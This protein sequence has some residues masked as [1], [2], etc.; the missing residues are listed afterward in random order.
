[1]SLRVGDDAPLILDLG[2]GVRYLGHQLR[3]EGRPFVGTALLT[4]LHW[5]HVQGLPFFPPVLDPDTR[6]DIYAPTQ[7][8]GRTAGTALFEM[9]KPP[10]F[11]VDISGLP[12]S[13]TV[14]TVGDEEFTVGRFAVTARFIPHIGPTLGYR[15]EYAGHSVAYLPDHQQPVDGGFDIADAVAELVD[16]ADVLIHDSQY[17]T[18]EFRHRATWGHCTGEYALHIARTCDVG[19]LVMF[20]HD[21]SR[22]DDD[23]ESNLTCWNGEDGR[24]QVV[25]AREGSTLTLGR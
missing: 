11:P 9:I 18:D 24:V 15:I 3:G 22:T 17:T 7:E 2:T 16:G 4:H 6:L 19:T 20:H 13:L 14:H 23:L 5:D 10:M 1:M 25:L 8:D 21:P 12:C